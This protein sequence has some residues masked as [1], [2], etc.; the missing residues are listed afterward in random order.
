MGRQVFVRPLTSPVR[1]PPPRYARLRLILPWR[2]PRAL[3]DLIEAYEADI[4][5]SA[6]SAY[7]MAQK[8]RLG[9]WPEVGPLLND[10]HFLTVQA[11]FKRLD[12]TAL[13]AIRGG[14][15]ATVHRDPFDRVLAAQAN[16]ERMRVVSKDKRL[17]ALGAETV[18]GRPARG[19]RFYP[20]LLRPKVR[21]SLPIRM[22]EYS[23]ARQPPT[24][25]PPSI[26]G[27]AGDRASGRRIRR[28]GRG[29]GV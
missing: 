28:G 25:F 21:T 26:T 8:Y 27:G 17:E 16:V 19:L 7:E 20:E 15:L 4:F 6:I 1:E 2:L 3:R 9:L 12:V 24:R 22:H 5:V 14:L 29:R 23:Q 11:R 18:W 13:H 10:F